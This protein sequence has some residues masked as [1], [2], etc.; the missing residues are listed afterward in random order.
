MQYAQVEC[1]ALG[2]SHCKI[3]YHWPN[4]YNEIYANKIVKSLTLVNNYIVKVA[5]IFV[6]KI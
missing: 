6:H 1:E 3:F 5:N 4:M 2:N